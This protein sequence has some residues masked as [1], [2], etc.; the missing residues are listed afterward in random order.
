MSHHDLK[1][2]QQLHDSVE[3]NVRGL[4][5]LGV[6]SNFY[7]SLLTSIL[8]DK[9]RTEIRLV[10]SRELTRRGMGHGGS[11]ESYLV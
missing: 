9:L 1:T 5:V 7:G 4:C 11:N 3:S 2:L 10:V 6:T 8:M